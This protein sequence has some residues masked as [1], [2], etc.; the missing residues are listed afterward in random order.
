MSEIKLHRYSD[1]RKRG[2]PTCSGVDAKSCMRCRGR[3]RMCDWWH[4]EGSGH[5][6]ISHMSA[7]ETNAAL[8]ELERIGGSDG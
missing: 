3:S 6:H 5:A 7:E 8:A 2:C 4:I 1:R